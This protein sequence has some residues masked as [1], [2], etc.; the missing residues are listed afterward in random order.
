MERWGLGG[1]DK[2]ERDCGY[3]DR[4]TGEKTGDRLSTKWAGRNNH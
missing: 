2:P 4:G 3:G 1:K